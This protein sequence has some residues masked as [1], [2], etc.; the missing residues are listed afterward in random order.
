MEWL[1]NTIKRGVNT[2]TGTADLI[3][4]LQK[5]T[6]YAPVVFLCFLIFLWI[7]FGFI[8]AVIGYKKDLLWEGFFLGIL[9]LGPLGW[10][11]VMLMQGNR[12]SC[13][14]CKELILKNAKLC[15]YCNHQTIKHIPFRI[16]IA[17]RG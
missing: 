17:G 13:P 12:I 14:H 9:L 8:G 16:R 7:L 6:D 10:V 1:G 3:D 5:L 2:I 15:R 11:I 4:Q